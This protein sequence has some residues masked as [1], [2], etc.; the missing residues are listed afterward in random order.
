MDE[1]DKHKNSLK[2]AHLSEGG[3]GTICFICELEFQL[4]ASQAECDQLRFQAKKD[5]ARADRN[6]K[7]Y[8][9]ALKRLDEMAAELRAAIS[10]ALP[11]D[12]AII[13]EHV[14][15]AAEIARGEMR[16][17]EIREHLN[18]GYWLREADEFEQLRLDMNFLLEL[19]EEAKECFE[20]LG[21]FNPEILK[22]G[23]IELWLRKVNS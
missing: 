17:E 9:E 8:V 15:R 16:L 6:A 14:R 5:A 13:M 1:C 23:K 3:T 7:E 19:V 2:Y 18:R 20:S 21:A 11:S 10:Q 22:L 12:D 4:T